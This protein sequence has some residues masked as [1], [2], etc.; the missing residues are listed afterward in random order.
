MRLDAPREAAILGVVRSAKNHLES[1][2][3]CTQQKKNSFNAHAVLDHMLLLLLGRLACGL[4]RQMSHVAW[5]VCVF[6]CLCVC[7]CVG[8]IDVPLKNY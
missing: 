8:H 5:S 1:L 6:V 4:L 2:L 7:L 3:R